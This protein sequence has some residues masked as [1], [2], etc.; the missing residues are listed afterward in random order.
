MQKEDEA[1]IDITL[2]QAKGHQELLVTP[3]VRERH[4]ADSSLELSR[5]HGHGSTLILAF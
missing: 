4:E 2:W 3:E 1:E 5:N